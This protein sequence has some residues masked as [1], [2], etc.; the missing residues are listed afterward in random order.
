MV[1]LSLAL[2]PKFHKYSILFVLNL[3]GT[4]MAVSKR[5][6][7]GQCF[8]EPGQKRMVDHINRLSFLVR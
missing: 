1:R 8:V 2:L 3:G 5:I 4:G 7:L 6:A